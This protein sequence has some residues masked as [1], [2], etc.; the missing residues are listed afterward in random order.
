MY[1]A[2]SS[3]IIPVF[4][5][6]STDVYT[7]K[8]GTEEDDSDDESK[9]SPIVVTIDDFNVGFCDTIV[10]SADFQTFVSSESAPVN[11][12][13]Y[14]LAVRLLDKDNKEISNSA[15]DSSMMFGN[16]LNYLTY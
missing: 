7:L 5:Q 1:V 3:Q 12:C 15:L 11:D 4:E 10:V 16:P 8:T 6:V 2:P 9:F 13:R 14:G